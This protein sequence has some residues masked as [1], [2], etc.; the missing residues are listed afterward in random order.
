MY[1]DTEKLKQKLLREHKGKKLE[2]V[3]GGKELKTKKGVC[4]HIENQDRISLKVINPEQERKK[5]LSDLKLIYGI[6]EVTEWI[7]KEE[8][9][10]TIEDLTEHP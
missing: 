10:K 5:I 7:L 6:G 3:I 9:Y 4:Y 1:Q 2:D 8:G